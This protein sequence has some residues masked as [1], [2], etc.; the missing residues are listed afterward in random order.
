MLPVAWGWGLSWADAGIVVVMY[1]ISGTTGYHRLFT[2]ARSVPRRRRRG[3]VLMLA[4]SGNRCR[5]AVS[6]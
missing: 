5:I 2:H 6:A 4:S 1:L 3:Y